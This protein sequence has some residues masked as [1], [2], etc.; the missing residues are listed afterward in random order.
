MQFPRTLVLLSILLISGG[1]KAQSDSLSAWCGQF[2]NE[3]I[4]GKSHEALLVLYQDS[5]EIVEDTAAWNEM[6]Y[7]LDQMTEAY[8]PI[9][10][11]DSIQQKNL[12]ESFMLLTYMGKYQYEPVRFTFEFYKPNKRWEIYGFAFDL[13]LVRDLEDA[14]R[15]FN[16]IPRGI[17]KAVD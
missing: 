1:L 7:Q 6:V 15:D 13:N 8:G 16:A 11:Y 17:K 5:P 10:G 2:F 4:D 9:F 14:S 12:G 3:L